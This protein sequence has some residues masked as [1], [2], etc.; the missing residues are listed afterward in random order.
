MLTTYEVDLV[1][2]LALEQHSHRSIS[3][4]AGV[5]RESVR[6]ILSGRRP[7]YDAILRGKEQAKIVPSGAAMRLPNMRG[8]GLHALS[9]LSHPR[10]EGI[11]AG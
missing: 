6:S 7:D 4:L 3:R 11:A 10:L 1:R 5:S 8:T 9:R 2:K